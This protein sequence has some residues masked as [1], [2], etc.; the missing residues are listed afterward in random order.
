MISVV[1]PLYNKARYI[2]R[3]LDSILA[4]TVHDIEVIVVDD[5]STDG[6]ADVVANSVDSRIRIVRQPNGGPGAARNRGIAEARGEILAFLDADDRWLP[7]FL[8]RNIELMERYHVSA[9]SAGY[10]EFPEND[11][12]T[13]VW[14]RRGVSEGIQPVGPRLAASS[15][16]GI[17][18]FMSPCSTVVRTS[19]VKR[20]GGF[21]EGRCRY[22]EDAIF[23]LKV[24]LNE[25][26]YFHFTPLVEFHRE[27]SQL[28][29]NLASA[30]PVE[31]FLLDSEIVTRDCPPELSYLVAKFLSIRANK[32]AIVLGSW[33]DWRRSAEIRSRFVTARTWNQPFFFGALLASN[34]ALALLARFARSLIQQARSRKGVPTRQSAGTA[35]SVALENAV[36]RQ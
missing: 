34:P 2:K 9:V 29:G 1:V 28:S 30:R 15:L 25:P 23:W 24:L 20:W 19:T 10:V 27:A 4:Q 35:S 16:V 17:L 32:T 21:Y 26:V 11:V 5:G 22:G 36:R 8:A 7:G 18:A 13:R 12:P 31:P 6:G 33:G 14:R 3:A